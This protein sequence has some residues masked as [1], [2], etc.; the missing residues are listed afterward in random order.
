MVSN[1]ANPSCSAI[2]RYLHEGTIFQVTART[3]A[4][5]KRLRGAR[6][7]RFWLCGECSKTMTIIFEPTGIRVMSLHELPDK[8]KQQRS[9]E[10]AIGRAATSS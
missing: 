5:V 10:I 9:C 2:F 1:C 3:P 4:E 6:H 8:Q 7:E